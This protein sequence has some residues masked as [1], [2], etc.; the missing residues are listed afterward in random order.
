LLRGAG[1][2]G[3]LAGLRFAYGGVAVRPIGVFAALVALT[4]C[5][6]V[7]FG[8]RVVSRDEVILTQ[9]LTIDRA[10]WDMMDG[11]EL[12]EGASVTVGKAVVTCMRDERR[13]VGIAPDGP[14]ATILTREAGGVRVGFPVGN[15]VS[16]IGAGINEE[17]PPG[18]IAEA[19]LVGRSLSWRVEGVEILAASVPFAPGA[20]SV[21]F[22]VPWVDVRKRP[23]AAP[24][25]FWA[26]VRTD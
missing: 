11:Q 4:G 22:V 9:L 12:C 13:A 15:R 10:A 8:A 21:E 5:V 17:I 2:R 14:A 6:D 16:E 7:E 18:H 26:V 19:S 3:R 25:E 23:E 24:A 1:E 20:K